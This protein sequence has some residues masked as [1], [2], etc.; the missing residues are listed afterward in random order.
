M[1]ARSLSSE[2]MIHLQKW[3]KNTK[4]SQHKDN[5]EASSSLTFSKA[6]AGSYGRNCVP[7]QYDLYKGHVH[8]Q[9]VYGIGCVPVVKSLE[10]KAMHMSCSIV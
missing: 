6:Y 8:T 4:Q 9:Y 10:K 3:L 7:T 2:K 5:H 1:E